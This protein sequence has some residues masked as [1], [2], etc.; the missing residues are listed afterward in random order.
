MTAQPASNLAS[1][2]VSSLV[3][4]LTMDE[5]S[6]AHFRRLGRSGLLLPPVSL[7]L[8][9]NFGRERFDGGS[10]H[11]QRSRPKA[12]F[13]TQRDIVLAAFEA[14]VT[15]FD[16]ANNYGPPAGS[17]EEVF[18]E[19]LRRDLAG[20]RDELLITSKAG[21]RMWRG[22]Y[23]DGGSRKYLL[24]SLDQSL[25]RLGV[26]YVDIFYHHRMDGD[27]PL[28]ESMGA[29]AHAVKSGKALYAGISNYSPERTREAA[30]ILADMGVPLTVHQASYSMLNR[31]VEEDRGAGSLLEVAE[32]LGFG[33]VAFSPLQQGLLTDRYLEGVPER[34]RAAQGVFLRASNATD[35]H[36]LEQVRAL[37]E[38]ARG[39]GQSLAQLA[40]AW[41]LRQR[42]VAT[43]IVGASSVEQLQG[44]LA[45][46]G[47]NA[48]A[49][50]LTESELNEIERALAQ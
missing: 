4:G 21:Y 31:H 39:R 37:N 1:S 44:N 48:A 12:D 50:E 38:I 45:A 47:P 26:E 5:S 25:A 6:Y 28:E 20:H 23:G 13:A 10:E 2:L 14:G 32:E 15:H 46:V 49:G 17:A 27:T 11:E 16:L 24:A 40:L 7:G 43:A 8:W 42:A 3:S 35:P 34:S 9:H 30:A 22:P 18:G 36:Y 33:V 29:L 41:I 19:I